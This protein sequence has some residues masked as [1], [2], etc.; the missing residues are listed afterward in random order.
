M[1]PSHSVPV[2]WIDE[3][4]RAVPVSAASGEG[5]DSLLVAIEQ[6]LFESMV[7]ISASIPYD[8]GRLINLIHEQGHLDHSKPGARG[9]LVEARVPAH[10]IE[11]FRPYLRRGK[12]RPLGESESLADPS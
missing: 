6:Q 8:Q 7:S 1:L 3:Y 4:E 5:V 2:E 12:R 11:V 9:T 10:M